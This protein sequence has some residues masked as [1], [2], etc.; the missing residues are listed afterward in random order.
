MFRGCSGGLEQSFSIDPRDDAPHRARPRQSAVKLSVWPREYH[1]LSRAPDW[2]TVGTAPALP[3]VFGRILGKMDPNLV[4]HLLKGGWKHFPM[5]LGVRLIVSWSESLWYLLIKEPLRVLK[6][7]ICG[8]DV[9]FL[10]AVY[11][12]YG[13]SNVIWGLRI[14]CSLLGAGRSY[15]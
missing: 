12:E 6:V 10:C 15:L 2:E 7:V 14:K 8:M 1:L 13:L 11:T 3:L 5:A 9:N 4:F